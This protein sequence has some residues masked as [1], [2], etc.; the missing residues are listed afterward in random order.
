VHPAGKIWLAG[1]AGPEGRA[2]RVVVKS[3]DITLAREAGRNLSIRNVLAGSVEG[4]ETDDG[5]FA[6]VS[7]ALDGHGHL[8]V[9]TTRKAIDDL[10]LGPGDRVFALIK[11]V[12]LDERAMASLEP[13][14]EN[15]LS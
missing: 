10:G 5:A 7:I 3:T 12:A 15:R 2:V 11:T 4:I 14:T 8:F 1:H 9:L 6:G 13:I